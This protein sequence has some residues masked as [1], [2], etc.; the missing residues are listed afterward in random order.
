MDI[1]YL[2]VERELRAS[3]APPPLTH[4]SP[5]HSPQRLSSPR[6]TVTNPLKPEH[7][8]TCINIELT[9]QQIE[10]Q[11]K[12]E[13]ERQTYALREKT[14]EKI[15]VL[16]RQVVLEIEEF[17]AIHENKDSIEKEEMETPI[18]LEIM[19]DMVQEG[20]SQ[21]EDE[22]DIEE[23]EAEEQ[24]TRLQDMSLQ[25]QEISNSN[26]GESNTMAHAL[27]NLLSEPEEVTGFPSLYDLN[28][29]EEFSLQSLQDVSD[30]DI[31]SLLS[32]QQRYESDCNNMHI[33]E[34]AERQS[35]EVTEKPKE[36]VMQTQ[37]LHPDI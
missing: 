22:D 35:E 3:S 34:E 25:H 32:F 27:Q 9:K 26:D 37:I 29:R 21:T 33:K 10:K 4:T 36:S 7:K 5:Q 30:L 16:P 14:E 23:A 20:E 19:V 24:E 17:V 18:E 13:M 11:N 15:A 1:T 31:V 6:L 2:S 28:I 12:Q 8:H